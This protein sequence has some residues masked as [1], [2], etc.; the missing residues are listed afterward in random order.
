V[1]ERRKVHN[2]VGKHEGG[3]K[4]LE[5]LDSDGNRPNADLKK[6]NFSIVNWILLSPDRNKKVSG[7]REGHVSLEFTEGGV[8]Y[9][10]LSGC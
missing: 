1:C 6:R 3:K 9:R 7:Y 2:I 10:S 8:V 4:K 5:D